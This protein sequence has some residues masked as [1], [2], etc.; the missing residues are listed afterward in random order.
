MHYN[1][2]NRNF[3]SIRFNKNTIIY[4]RKYDYINTFEKDIGKATSILAI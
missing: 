4:L 2:I 1:E 3:Y